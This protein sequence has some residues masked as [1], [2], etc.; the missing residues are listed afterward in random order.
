MVDDVVVEAHAAAVAVLYPQLFV[1]F[2]QARTAI[3]GAGVLHGGGEQLAVEAL[4]LGGL[5]AR[6]GIAAQV[7][8]AVPHV[9]HHVSH[10][11][12]QLHHCPRPFAATYGHTLYVESHNDWCPRCL[13]SATC[14]APRRHRKGREK[15][16]PRRGSAGH[17]YVFGT[18]SVFVCILWY[19]IGNEMYFG[20]DYRVALY[21]F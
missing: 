4:P 19:K 11:T 1:G 18:N 13:R 8:P 21:A 2:A 3:D 16:M 12:V 7:L 17:S 5:A 20:K 10:A 15:E 6:H 9:I 14:P